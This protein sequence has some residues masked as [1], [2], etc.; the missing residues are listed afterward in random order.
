MWKIRKQLETDTYNILEK[1]ASTL[2]VTP[3]YYTF[4]PDIM[5]KICNIVH[6]K[7]YD[8]IYKKWEN[9]TVDECIYLSKDTKN[10]EILRFILPKTNINK[11]TKILQHMLNYSIEHNILSMFELLTRQITV[12]VQFNKYDTYSTI[13]RIVNDNKQLALKL[14]RTEMIK[15]FK[16]FTKLN[17]AYNNYTRSKS[18]AAYTLFRNH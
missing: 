16:N 17:I 2:A 5:K 8:F 1:K 13:S 14:N 3:I 11:K 15:Y 7:F 9:I 12:V 10:T 18:I 4:S 6:P